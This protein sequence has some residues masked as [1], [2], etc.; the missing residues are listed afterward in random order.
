MQ[1]QLILKNCCELVSRIRRDDRRDA[2]LDSSPELGMTEGAGM[3]G[4]VKELSGL[5]GRLGKPREIL[6]R[7]MV[8]QSS[9]LREFTTLRN[10]SKV[11]PT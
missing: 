5:L 11:L 6:W 10:T 2:G 7:K 9:L 8:V 1:Y 3:T 4:K